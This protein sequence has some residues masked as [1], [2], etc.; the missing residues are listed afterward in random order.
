MTKLYSQLATVYHEMYQSI[1]DYKQEFKSYKK[2]LDKYKSKN[3]LEIGC[4]SGN[5]APYFLKAGFSYTGL[6]LSNE[7]INI[8][9]TVKPKGNFVQGD[10]RNLKFRNKFDTILI[11]GRSF[12][13][14][15]TNDDVI[16]TLKSICRS[17]KKGGYLIFDNFN[18]EE[19]IQIN[20]KKFSQ[21]VQYKNRKYRR[22]TVKTPNLET[23]WTESWDATYYI[24]ENK[25]TKI[26][27][28]KSILR[29]FTLDE[30]SLFLKITKFNIVKN[31]KQDFSLFTIAQK[32]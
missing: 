32:V 5:L 19:M 1:F 8:A 3:I 31:T 16:N 23:G 17:L 2:Y 30:L 20:K 7:M 25:K 12:T 24:T 11:T 22:E 21:T 27:K 14:L 29:S 15:I 18:A 9:K 6:D 4:G 13:Y 10:M 28:D 26:L